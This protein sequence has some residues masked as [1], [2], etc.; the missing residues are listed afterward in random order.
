MLAPYQC[1]VGRDVTG[2]SST[3]SKFASMTAVFFSCPALN[4]NPIVV[5][6]IGFRNQVVSKLV[7]V[8]LVLACSDPYD[9]DTAPNAFL[10]KL[11]PIL[12]SNVFPVLLSTCKSHPLTA[13]T[14][15]SM[16]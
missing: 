8:L 15:R 2:L 4:C 9:N 13:P 12:A 5:L 11:I 1:A 6:S 16:I 10:P 7:L 14:Q 3:P